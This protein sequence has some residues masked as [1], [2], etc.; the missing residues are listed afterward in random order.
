MSGKLTLSEYGILE[1]RKR[2]G[3][4]AV[5]LISATPYDPSYY[6]SNTQSRI[7]R[8][9]NE[10]SFSPFCIQAPVQRLI[11]YGDKYTREALQ[12]EVIRSSLHDIAVL[13]I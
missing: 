12:Y 5:G 13:R 9:I 4:A 11:Y 6:I 8:I 3:K 7:S 2:S 1:G 10:F